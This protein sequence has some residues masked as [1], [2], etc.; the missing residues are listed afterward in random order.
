MNFNDCL[1]K[2][3]LRHA[4]SLTKKWVKKRPHRLPDAALYH[5]SKVMRSVLPMQDAI[6]CRKANEGLAFPFS[7]REM[8]ACLV[9]I[10]SANCFWV[11]PAA[12]RLAIASRIASYCVLRCQ[13]VI[14]FLYFR[15]FCKYLLFVV[16]VPHSCTPFI[17]GFTL[18]QIME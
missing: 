10:F 12:F 11:S 4:L 1:K 16:A 15:V 3:S 2:S 18:N 5:H 6:F 8:F 17:S 9:P 13:A 7:K 14:L